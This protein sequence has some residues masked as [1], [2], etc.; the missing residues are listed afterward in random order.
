MVLGEVQEADGREIDAIEPVLLEAIKEQ[1]ALIIALRV[2]NG[3][4]KAQLTESNAFSSYINEQLELLKVDISFL[5]S[6]SDLTGA[7]E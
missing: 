2:D 7:H 4:L 5:K 3:T 1:Q 6:G